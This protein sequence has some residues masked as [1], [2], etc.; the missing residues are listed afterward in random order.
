MGAYYE[1]VQTS[2]FR[3]FVVIPLAAF[4]AVLPLIVWGTSCGHD[5]GFHL[6]NWLEVSSQWKQGVL[7]PHWEFTAAWNSGEPRF[8]FYPPLSWITGAALGLL[9]P[10]IA[11]PTVFI[12]L[13]LT[14]SG[15]TMYRLAS[16]W[17]TSS[18]ALIAACFYMVNP[19]MLFTFYERAAYA[20]LLAAAWIPLLLLGILQPRLTIYSIAV[21]ICLLWLSNDPAA[22]IGCYSFALLSLIRVVSSYRSA[23][24]PLAC[25]EEAAKISAGTI[26]GIGLAA[27]YILPATIEQHWIQINMPFMRGVRYQDNFAFGHIGD[28]SHDAILSTASLCGI[29]LVV[30]CG[31]FAVIALRVG[32]HDNARAP[33]DNEARNRAILGALALLTCVVAFLLTASSTFLWKHV[34]ELKYLQFPWRFCMILG[35]T[36]AALLALALRRTRLR[37]VVG[38]ATALALTLALTLGGNHIFRQSCSPAFAVPGIV[39][40]FYHGGHYDPTDE[41]TPVGA[42]PLALEHAN[43]MFWIAAHPTD[44][45]P[46]TGASYSI[47]LAHRL[48]FYVSSAIPGFVVL[49]LRDYPAWRITVNGRT[50]G[51]RPHRKDGLIALPINS[52]VSKVDIA[53][54][55]TPDQTAG[56]MISALSGAILLFIGWRHERHPSDGASVAQ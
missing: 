55:R 6:R 26:L 1:C 52:G 44:P 56:W 18:I 27:F 48:H 45:A 10:W 51:A 39:H 21:P 49:S 36:A 12:W 13:A 53:Y 42:D 54:A 50:V 24:G 22:V 43:P 38:A 25:F 2:G 40:D 5:F 32:K 16:E 20:E 3:H 9:L 19:Y 15:F 37:P 17:T 4:L 46:Q 30:L 14:A 31:V 8:I 23:Q 29:T 41:Y 28:V 35:T 33:S 34:P 47:A 7:V 11:V